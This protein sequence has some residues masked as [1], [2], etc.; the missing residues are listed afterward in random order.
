MLGRCQHAARRELALQPTRPARNT[1]A[2]DDPKCRAALTQS[3]RRSSDF[4][5]NLRYAVR[6]TS[7]SRNESISSQEHRPRRLVGGQ[8]VVAARQRTRSRQPGISAAKLA[9]SR[10]RH[11]AVVAGVQHQRRAAAPSAR[12]RDV[13]LGERLEEAHR[14]VGRRRAALQLVEVLPLLAGAVGQ[15]LRR[16]HLAERRVVAAPADARH[17]EVEGRL[18]ALLLRRR[19]H[20]PAPAVGAAQDQR[21]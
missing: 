21:G 7:A 1:L 2:S 12:A 4:L 15:E 9:G 5:K 3:W 19:P 14:V 8:D 11:A 6:S 10:Q 16:E 17:L 20:E 13:D 18:T